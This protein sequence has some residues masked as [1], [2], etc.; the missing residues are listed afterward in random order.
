MNIIRIKK[1]MYSIYFIYMILLHSYKLHQCV[2]GNSQHSFKLSSI[3]FY[4][5]RHI[6]YHKYH[7]Y[8]HSL[9]SILF[10]SLK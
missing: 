9:S 4:L 1:Y 8:I 7:T 2:Y 6:K 3:L 5:F 10:R